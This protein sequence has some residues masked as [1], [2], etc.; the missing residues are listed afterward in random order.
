WFQWFNIVRTR[1]SQTT[2]SATIDGKAQTVF[3]DLIP[4]GVAPVEASGSVL[5]VA[6]PTDTT[7]NV[8]GRIVA[9]MLRTPAT[10]NPF[11]Y[12]PAIRYA[13]AAINATTNPLAKRGAL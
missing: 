9:T 10:V 4:L 3:G 2:S 5:W 11:S 1:V 7:V 13:N 12:P 6:D 8:Q